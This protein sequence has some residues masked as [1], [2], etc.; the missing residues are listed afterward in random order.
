MIREQVLEKLRC[1]R[2]DVEFIRLPEV[3][4]EHQRTIKIEYDK[5]ASGCL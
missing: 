2:S 1:T 5:Q 4:L 3:W